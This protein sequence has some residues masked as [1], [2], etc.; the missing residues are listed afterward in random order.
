MLRG[1]EWKYRSNPKIYFH[2]TTEEIVWMRNRNECVWTGWREGY[3]WCSVRGGRLTASLGE[4]RGVCVAVEQGGQ[5]PP[6]GVGHTQDHV[7]GSSRHYRVKL[8]TTRRLEHCCKVTSVLS[9][10]R[11]SLLTITIRDDQKMTPILC[12]RLL[13]LVVMSQHYKNTYDKM[14]TS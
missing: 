10:S 7:T 2:S 3:I 1:W 12:S 8:F 14:I 13:H 5:E 6:T 11:R 4:R 9:G